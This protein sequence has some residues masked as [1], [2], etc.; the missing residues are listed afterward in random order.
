M[1]RAAKAEDPRSF[2]V[3][4]DISPEAVA[5]CP[6]VDHYLQRNV[7]AERPVALQYF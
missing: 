4:Q 6:W 5:K 1:C 3:A 2:T 7:S